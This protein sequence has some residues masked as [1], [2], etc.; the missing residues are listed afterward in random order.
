MP[1]KKHFYISIP[2]QKPDWIGKRENKTEYY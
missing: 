1:K 2:W